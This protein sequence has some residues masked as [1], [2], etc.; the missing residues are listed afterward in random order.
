MDN[1]YEQ[2]LVEGHCIMVDLPQKNKILKFVESIPNEC[3]YEEEGKHY[4]KEKNPHITLMYGLSPIEENRVKELLNK[5]PKKIMAE[6]GQISKFQNADTPYDVLKIEVKSSHLGK[7]H[8]MIRKNFENDYKWPEY[9]PHVTLAYVKKGTCSELVGS[10]IFEGMKFAFENFTYSNGNREQNHKVNMKEYFIGQSGGYGGGAMAGG[11]VS[12]MNWAGTPSSNQ[13]SRRLNDYPASRRYTYMQGNTV[14]GSS[15]YD[16]ITKD[17]LKHPKFSSQEIFTGLRKEMSRMEYP[18]KDVAKKTVLSNLEKDPKFYSDLK[19]YFNS[20][21][22]GNNI[23]ENID[24][25]E[26]EAGTKHEHEH[27]NDDALARKIAMDHLKEDP[28]YYT[29]LKAAG[30]EEGDEHP[31]QKADRLSKSAKT[32]EEHK[33]A[34]DAHKAAAKHHAGLPVQSYRTYNWKKHHADAMAKHAKAAGLEEGAMT[35][36]EAGY[37]EECGDMGDMGAVMPVAPNVAVIKIDVPTDAGQEKLS[38]S[39]LGKSG[40]PKPLKTTN[41]EAPAEKSKVG[42]NKVVVSK[43]PPI[44]GAASCDPLDHFGAQ[45]NEKW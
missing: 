1:N 16:T 15:L 29:K 25:K 21:K 8:E 38:S 22:E 43:T 42:A 39:G 20:D 23:M 14:I 32:P 10:K 28:H 12:P 35:P 45:M 3:V 2:L 27:T 19:M 36:L 17:D 9:N 5:V 18:D 40:T 4:G 41:I 26:I 44:G 13:T 33:A 6:L 34:H 11:G 37:V 31:T 30:L 24:Q 7:I